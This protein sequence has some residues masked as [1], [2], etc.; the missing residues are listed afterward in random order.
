M[1]GFFG[2][3]AFFDDGDYDGGVEVGL[4]KGRRREERTKGEKEEKGKGARKE[5]VSIKGGLLIIW[6]FSWY[7]LAKEKFDR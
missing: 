3:E 5:V 2:F 7:N 6:I 1:V 4:E